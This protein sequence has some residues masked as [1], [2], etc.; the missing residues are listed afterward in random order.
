MELESGRGLLLVE[1]EEIVAARAMELLSD[2]V[3][4]AE[5]SRLARSEMERLY[6]LE[7]TYGRLVRELREW[8]ETRRERGR[9]SGAGSQRPELGDSVIPFSGFRFQVSAFCFFCETRCLLLQALL[10]LRGV[11]H[12]LR[13][14]RGVPLSDGCHRG[15]F[16]RDRSPGARLSARGWTG[17]DSFGRSKA[18]G[19]GIASAVW[20]RVRTQTAVSLVVLVLCSGHPAGIPKRGRCPRSHPRRHRHC[21]HVARV[22]FSQA[23]ICPVLRELA[24]TGHSRREVLAM[25]HGT[26][27][28]RPERDVGHRWS[29]RF[30]VGKDAA[31]SLDFRHEPDRIRDSRVGSL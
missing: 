14:G 5:Q 9:R 21:G 24:A 13:D 7:N 15:T 11:S 18:P 10:A 3:R 1:S 30:T 20:F 12:R 4:L 31:C 23:T 22:G 29:S 26:V 27:C 2:G 19:V 16:R 25:V 17:R 28:R 8:L 6:S